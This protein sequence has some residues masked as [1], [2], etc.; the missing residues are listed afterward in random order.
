MVRIL[1]F[2]LKIFLVKND[3]AKVSAVS[4]QWN[5]LTEKYYTNSLESKMKINGL[6]IVLS[7][8]VQKKSNNVGDSI[9]VFNSR[10][11]IP[12]ILFPADFRRFFPADFAE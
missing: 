3:G 5:I 4:A 10:N 2:I 8:F 1:K 6:G 9:L 11:F 12:A 7:T